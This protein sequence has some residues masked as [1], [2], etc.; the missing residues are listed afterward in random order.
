MRLV[1]LLGFGAC[2]ALACAV[3]AAAPPPGNPPAE[4]VASTEGLVSLDSSGT[5]AT[6]WITGYLN[7]ERFELKAVRVVGSRLAGKSSDPDQ[8]RATLLD[9]KGNKLGLVKMWS[10]L[11][12]LQ[13]DPEGLHET[14]QDLAERNVVIQVPATLALNQVVFTWPG[15]KSEAG[16]VQLR[17]EIV[18]F[19]KEFPA[20]PACDAN[21]ESTR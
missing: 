18:A 2:A 1:R 9:A 7:R 15:G 12:S 6:L 16:R 19:C 10:P 13:W 8:F 14:A 21:G 11:L 3:A 4:P 17:D 5:G 20:N